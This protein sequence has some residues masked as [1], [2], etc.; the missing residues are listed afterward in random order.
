MD[1]GVETNLTTTSEHEAEFWLKKSK[2]MNDR[3]YT[4]FLVQYEYDPDRDFYGIGFDTNKDARSNFS[5]RTVNTEIDFG[6]NITPTIHVGGNFSYLWADNGAGENKVH[7]S[8]EEKFDKSQIPAFDE[9]ENI[10]VEDI[11]T[12][13]VV[14]TYEDESLEEALKKLLD[15]GIGRLPVVDRKDTKKL[16]GLLTKFDIIRIHA[17]LSSKLCRIH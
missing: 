17:Q 7:S 10:R 14:V 16:L 13:S 8:I 12:T 3:F 6:T 2:W 4:N 15:N 1:L 9:R 11:M 5:L